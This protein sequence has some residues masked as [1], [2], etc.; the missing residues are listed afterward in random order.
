MSM[1]GWQRIQVKAFIVQLHA[2]LAGVFRFTLL[3]QGVFM[4]HFTAAGV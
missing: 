1:V 2:S 3:L 4:L